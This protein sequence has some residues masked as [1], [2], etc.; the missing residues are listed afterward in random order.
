MTAFL[1]YYVTKFTNRH[2]LQVQMLHDI[3]N[4]KQ[5]IYTSFLFSRL[6][7]GRRFATRCQE[8]RLEGEQAARR[9]A[10]DRPL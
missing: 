2:L 9:P 3:T 5:G 4:K 6:A 7:L 10:H 1:T 8:C